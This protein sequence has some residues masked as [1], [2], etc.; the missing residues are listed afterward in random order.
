[1]CLPGTKSPPRRECWPSPPWQLAPREIKHGAQREAGPPVHTVPSAAGAIPGGLSIGPPAKSSLDDSYGRYDLIQ[2][3]ESPASPPAAVPH[4][5]SRAKSDSDKI[6]NGS[7]INWPPGESGGLP[8]H[9]APE[10]RAPSLALVAESLGPVSLGG[11]GCGAPVRGP[12]VQR[13]ER[14]C[15]RDSASQRRASS[16]GHAGCDVASACSGDGRATERESL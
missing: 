10:S 8:L 4:S 16:L 15:G 6:S 3:S 14:C 12:L 1:M 5:W 9:P 11:R 13:K 7:S 2:N